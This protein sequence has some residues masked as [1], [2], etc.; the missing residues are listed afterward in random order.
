MSDHGTFCWNELMTPDVETAKTFYAATLGWSYQPH[1]MADGSTYW[2]AFVA[3]RQQPVA[4]LMHWPQDQM[5]SRAWFAYAAVDDIDAAVGK[6]RAA[7]GTL[8]KE[9]W[10]IEGVGRIAVVADPAGAV[11]GY[12]E[13]LPM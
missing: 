2:L 4:G 8:I 12:L 6:V 9:P 1:A 13:P 7:G 3:D 10:L 11:L 5:G